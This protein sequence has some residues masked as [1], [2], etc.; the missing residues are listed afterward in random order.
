MVKDPQGESPYSIESIV[1]SKSALSEKK[2]ESSEDPRRTFRALMIFI[3]WEVSSADVFTFSKAH[4]AI[5]NA[6]RSSNGDQ[7]IVL[8]SGGG[9]V[10][11][12]KN[13]PSEVVGLAEK[14]SLA[15]RIV[16]QKTLILTRQK[17]MP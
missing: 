4:S 3:R 12:G 11:A 16:S 14:Y 9:G 15:Q 5:S 2:P 7:S 10:P 6:G 1:L 17:L 13:S 8:S